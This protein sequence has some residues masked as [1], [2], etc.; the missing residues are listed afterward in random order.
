MDQYN[1]DSRGQTFFLPSVNS[2]S[3]SSN[4]K[5][6]SD[7][8]AS[9]TSNWRI[10]KKGTNAWR[11]NGEYKV[12]VPFQLLADGTI[13]QYQ[14][15]Q[16]ETLQYNQLQRLNFPNNTVQHSFLPIQSGDIVERQQP[17]YG[18]N[19]V[20]VKGTNEMNQQQNLETFQVSFTFEK[21]FQVI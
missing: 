7:I 13:P 14:I 16:K 5:I 15:N 6:I 18:S 21:Y 17:N 1:S 8:P 11:E 10:E 3:A 9:S 4:P 19:I 12:E 2:N 20:Y